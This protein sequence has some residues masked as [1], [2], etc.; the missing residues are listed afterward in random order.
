MEITKTL[1]LSENEFYL[2]D[3]HSILNILTILVSEIEVS[4]VITHQT[5]LIRP[6]SERIIELKAGLNQELSKIFSES[7]LTQLAIDAEKVFND[8]MIYCNGNSELQ[9][10]VI[11]ARDNVSRIIGILNVRVN[12]LV[13]RKDNFLKWDTVSVPLLEQNFGEVLNAIAKNSKGKYNIVQN[14]AKKLPRDYVVNFD[15]ESSSNDSTIYMPLTLQD[16]VRDLIANARKYTPPGGIIN[17]GL[18]SDDEKIRVVIQDNGC[19]IPEDEIESVVD[20]GYR[21]SNTA[22]R[23]TKGGGFGLTKAYYLTKRLEGRF[24]IDSEVNKGTTI[25]IEI[26]IARN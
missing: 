26:P 16:C 12:E 11:E 20:F 19:G 22:F 1:D 10:V 9:Q 15:I 6:L 7:A 17:A 18:F 21:A 8:L 5:E 4:G 3:H 13:L 2:L 14:I 24:W 23:P 25:T